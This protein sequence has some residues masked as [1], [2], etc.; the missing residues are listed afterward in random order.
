MKEKVKYD[1]EVRTWDV[2]NKIR[3]EVT[4]VR[5]FKTNNLI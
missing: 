3:I 4:E 2:R 5:T 1:N